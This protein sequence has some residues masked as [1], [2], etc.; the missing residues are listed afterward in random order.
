VIEELRAS[1]MP[2]FDRPHFIKTVLG[3]AMIAS[4]A[5]TFS[6]P[7][8]PILLGFP[9]IGIGFILLFSSLKPGDNL[10]RPKT[11][12]LNLIRLGGSALVVY[13]ASI[14]AID[15]SQFI[16]D[17]SRGLVS[18]PYRLPTKIIALWFAAPTLLTVGQYLR[19]SRTSP[20]ALLATWAIVFLASVGSFGLVKMFGAYSA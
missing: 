13:T 1:S 5:A 16:I 2:E 17:Q 12:L 6:R 3:S 8:V 7:I 18:G 4:G 20:A 15:I 11:L 14:T 9:L 19:D 10:S